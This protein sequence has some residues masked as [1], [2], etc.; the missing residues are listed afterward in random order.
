MAESFQILILFGYTDDSN[1]N[2]HLILIESTGILRLMCISLSLYRYYY[3][4]LLL[5]C[6]NG[7]KV[8]NVCKFMFCISVPG[9]NLV[10][11]YKYA[12]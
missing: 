1:G 7:F 12:Y 6:F 5:S 9:C 2:N 10:M 4:G 8:L 11:I 3:D